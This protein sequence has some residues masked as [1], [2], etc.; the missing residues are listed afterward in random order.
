MVSQAASSI[1]FLWPVSLSIWLDIY[2]MSPNIY[3]T[4]RQGPSARIHRG[5]QKI[6]YLLPVHTYYRKRSFEQPFGFLCKMR[7]ANN[8]WSLV[9]CFWQMSAIQNYRSHNFERKQPQK[10][11]KALKTILRP[12]KLVLKIGVGMLLKLRWPLIT[13]DVWYDFI[14]SQN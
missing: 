11:F 3:Q 12:S 14:P 2:Q 5:L 1:L 9:T 6:T 8:L 7:R 10:S 4:R 13:F